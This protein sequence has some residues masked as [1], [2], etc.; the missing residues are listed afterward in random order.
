MPFLLVEGSDRVGGRLATDKLGGF[1]LDRGFQV[2]LTAYPECR[3]LLDYTKL[4]L[5]NFSAGSLV[6]SGGGLQTVIDPFRDPGSALATIFAPVG[7]FGDKMK[8]FT[9]KEDLLNKPVD[10]IFKQSSSSTIDA[11]KKYGFSDDMIKKFFKPFMGGIFLESDLKTSSKMF[12]FVF[13]MFSQGYAA[14]PS[15]GMQAI[16]EQLVAKIPADHVR[17][18]TKVIAIGDNFVETDNGEKI[19]ARAVVVAT[20]GTEAGKLIKGFPHVDTQAVTCLYFEAPEAPIK[21]PILILNGEGKGLV[22]NVCV[23]TNVAP[24]YGNG[25]SHLVSVS[26][27]GNPFPDDGTADVAVKKELMEWFGSDVATWRLLRIYRVVNALPAQPPAVLEQ[28]RREVRLQ[29]GLYVCGDHRDNASING[30]MES[31]RRTAREILSSQD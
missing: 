15:D 19:E 6:W 13:S 3:R 21:Q 30:A 22:N 10:E 31:G 17:L 8:V 7:S 9:L 18:K 16:P 12:E 1:L 23:P 26:V 28:P 2:L 4:K 5:N 24:S 27:L 29:K 11:L 20:E 14:L 25:K